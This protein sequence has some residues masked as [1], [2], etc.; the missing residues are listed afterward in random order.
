[1]KW[2]ALALPPFATLLPRDDD[3]RLAYV[4]ERRTHPLN[5]LIRYE[6]SFNRTFNRA[7]RQLQLLQKTRPTPD[8]GSFRN[9]PAGAA[10]L[11]LTPRPRPGS[12]L[13]LCPCKFGATITATMGYRP[14]ARQRSR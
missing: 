3:Q 7:L 2:P 6:A 11:A 1:M 12:A 13:N 14:S 5:L 10:P 4:F 8:L 9:L